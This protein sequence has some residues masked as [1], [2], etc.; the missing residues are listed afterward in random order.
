MCAEV[1]SVQTVW[2]SR[3]KIIKTLKLQ[4]FT[5]IENKLMGESCWV[6]SGLQVQT[7]MFNYCIAWT[8]LSLLNCSPL[9]SA[10][11]TKCNK[12]LP[13]S[14]LFWPSKF[15]ASHQKFF[16][17]RGFN[18]H[19][20]IAILDQSLK[21]FNLEKTIFNLG[22]KPLLCSDL[23]KLWGLRIFQADTPIESNIWVYTYIWILEDF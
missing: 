11:F 9:F 7:L 15:N 18:T 13:F 3:W 21:L 19:K 6:M 1:N 4:H 5:E 2:F 14:F 8:F 16:K 20:I 12:P 17:Q 23:I 22:W 10:L